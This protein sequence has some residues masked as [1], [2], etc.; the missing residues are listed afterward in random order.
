MTKYLENAWYVAAFDHDVGRSPLRRVLLDRPVV[1]YRTES[2]KPVALLD[3]C[4]HRLVPLSRGK[5]IGDHIECAYHGLRFDQVGRCSLNP[6]GGGAIPSALQVISFP[7]V[8]RHG[9]VWIWPGDSDRADPAL[10]PGDLAF[11]DAPDHAVGKGYLH[12]KANYQLIVD[13]LL[14]LSHVPYVHPQFGAPGLSPMD[15][16]GLTETSLVRDGYT[17]WSRRTL[18]GAPP[19]EA[20][21]RRFGITADR[22]NRRTHM[23]WFPPSILHFD[24]GHTECTPE[25]RDFA[26]PAGHFITPESAVTS[27]HFFAQAR[28]V[29]IDDEKMGREF[30]EFAKVAFR[31]Q[32]VPLLEAQQAAV[33]SA[34]DLMELNPALLKT[35]AA[36]A[37][38]RRILSTLLAVDHGRDDSNSSPYSGSHYDCDEP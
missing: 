13:N 35:D 4:P 5:L 16:L 20:T 17:V 2:G 10:I 24:L 25:A 11:I 38:V 23:H 18:A 15:I 28:N 8:E 33:G 31:E 12:V 30:L 26:T 22:V 37:T 19:A 27:H 36:A 34:A 14:D 1:M 7:L 32:D 21:K 29:M 6:H 3:R 9:F